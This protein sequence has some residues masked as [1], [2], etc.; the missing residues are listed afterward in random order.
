VFVPSS[1]VTAHHESANTSPG[2]SHWYTHTE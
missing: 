1:V 2:G